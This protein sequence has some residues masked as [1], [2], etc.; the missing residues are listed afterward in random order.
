[1]G[2]LV[3]SLVKVKVMDQKVKETI[4]YFAGKEIKILYKTFLKTL[5]AMEQ[6]GLITNEIFNNARKEVLDMGNESIRSFAENLDNVEKLFDI[7]K[8]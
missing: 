4:V 6:K 2:L 7:K 8:N 5:E 1:L 3:Y